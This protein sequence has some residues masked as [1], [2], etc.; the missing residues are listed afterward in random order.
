MATPN[1]T[2]KLQYDYKALE[3]PSNANFISHTGDCYYMNRE[4]HLFTIQ[5]S[6]GEVFSRELTQPCTMVSQNGSN[7]LFANKDGIFSLNADG[8]INEKSFNSRILKLFLLENGNML[9]ILICRN[10]KALQ[11]TLNNCVLVLDTYEGKCNI[12]I[13]HAELWCNKLLLCCY[14]INSEVKYAIVG[15]SSGQFVLLR[16]DLLASGE[17]ATFQKALDG[18]RTFLLSVDGKSR[19]VTCCPSACTLI[20]HANLP[21]AKA[22][23][24]NVWLLNESV[25]LVT[26]LHATDLR[27][28]LSTI[29][30]NSTIATFTVPLDKHPTKVMHVRLKMAQ[31][32]LLIQ[33]EDSLV[34]LV[35]IN[36]PG[37]LGRLVL[38]YNAS[39]L[40]SLQSL[41]ENALATGLKTGKIPVTN[42]LVAHVMKMRWFECADLCLRSGNVCE[43]DAIRL[44]NLN[45]S[46]LGTFVEH[47]HGDQR[48]L[49]EAMKSNLSVQDLGIWMGRLISL[50][51]DGTP[52][53]Q[54][55]T[56]SL[57]CLLLDAKMPVLEYER[58][59]ESDWVKQLI[60]LVSDSLEENFQFSSLLSLCSS[61]SHCSNTR[62]GNNPL[63]SHSYPIL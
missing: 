22:N 33:L 26:K 8:S 27:V 5:D 48:E 54:R 37:N 13:L 3:V 21:I 15:F 10:K 11:L 47:Y 46:H 39:S 31:V 56:S 35:G 32:M 25:A 49:M 52:T 42:Q 17:V 9:L 53:M 19:L 20:V 7:V 24:G 60:L 62:G 34:G 2:G 44:V 14:K 23:A 57:M 43:R 63:V 1:H 6:T 4:R 28:Y 51:K 40:G 55:K 18:S 16:H 29:V 36:I 61:L 45:S 41:D 30:N 59:V 50:F 12:Q 58:E 38:E